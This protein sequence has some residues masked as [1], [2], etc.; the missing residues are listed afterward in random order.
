[1]YR[2]SGEKLIFL[3]Q[4]LS[5]KG[6]YLAMDNRLLIERL[7]LE[8]AYI[9]RHWDKDG[10]PLV[11]MTIKHNMLDK[12]VRKK[13]LIEFIEELQSGAT[14]GIALQLGNLSDFAETSSEEKINYLHDFQFSKASWEDAER[15]FFQVL[16]ISN[17]PSEPLSAQELTHLEIS[18]DEVLIE[19]LK[20]NANLYAQLEALSLLSIRHGLDYATGLTTADGTACIV[21]DLLE[22]IYERAGDLHI[23]YVVRRS[24]G[25]LGK[26]EI[27]LEQA[28]TEILVRQ[29]E[30]T[31]GRA[32]SGKATLTRPADSSVI[33][34]TIRTFNSNDGSEH[35][36]IQELILYLGMLVKSNPEL[37]A[38]MHTVRV[39]HILQLIIVRQA[40]ESNSTLDQAFNKILSL[41]PYQLSRK[42]RETLE[43]Y[44]NT[45]NQLGLVET[46]HYEGDCREL[47]SARFAASMNPKDRGD[48]ADWYEWREQK[49]SVGREND[50]F[51]ACVWDILH[52][53]QGLMIGEKLNSK[54]RLDSETTLSQM[55][56]G[57]QSFKLLVNH[58]LNKIQSPVYR[59]LTVE[60]LRAIA[61]IFRDNPTLQIEDT[62]LTDII[63]GHAV[64]ISWLQAHP[65]HKDNYDEV[66]SLAWQ[67]FYQLPPHNVANGILDALIHL[68][69]N[70]KTS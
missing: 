25:L 48:A 35:I 55:T 4:F 3:P 61:S 30:L 64:R 49:G 17:S 20:V 65:D 46:L 26:Y 8:L 12:P 44:D 24:A 7:R 5:Q 57:E 60:A 13:I 43:D 16:P 68:L 33:L 2:L 37:F 58:L 29:H 50:A 21:R 6:F 1:M 23:W 15:A 36:I 52:H 53:C 11:V 22:E 62:L 42:V 66:V 54:R 18:A 27:N 41:S 14:Q 38:D 19:Q 31:L 10:N 28:A 51:F 40:R 56:S 63:V 67:A 45:E 9:Y 47:A 59:Q 70:N 34:Q 69:N 39:G 32:Y